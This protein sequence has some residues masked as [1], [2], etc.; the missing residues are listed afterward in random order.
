LKNGQE[1]KFMNSLT[2]GRTGPSY[3][4]I[5]Q[6]SPIR[7]GSTGEVN[8]GDAHAR[9]YEA[10]YRGNVF[11]AA[12]QN[13]AFTSSVGITT[14]TIVG[15]VLSNPVASGKN[16]VLMTA[17]FMPS[18]VVVGAV[19]LS[20][21]PFSAT[22]YTHTTTLTVQKALVSLGNG[23]VTLADQGATVSS[24]PV[25]TKFLFSCLSTNTAQPSVATVVDLGGQII[26]PP[27]CGVAIDG[28]QAITGW[29]SLTWEEVP[30]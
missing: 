15:L 9:Y 25:P 3:N 26:V 7:L 6:N 28:T 8:T 12:T 20:T 27:G 16:L 11:F 22:A 5:G 23:S 30:I 29:A 21:I 13:A 14:T 17:E 18:G 24:T 10:V 19:A 2:Y 1:I 4:S